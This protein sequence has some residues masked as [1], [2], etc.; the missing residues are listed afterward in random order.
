[1]R[2]RIFLSALIVVGY[3]ATLGVSSWHLAEWYSLTKGTLP[4]WL[5]FA[6]A[7]T[8][9]FNA[10]LLSFLSNSFLAR[11]PWARGG[12]VAALG[13]VWLGNLLSMRRSAPD[14]AMWE[15]VAAS[16]F[17]PVGT[18][19]MAK[20]MGELWRGEA[21]VK[22]APREEAAGEEERVL[23]LLEKP[24]RVRDLVRALPELRDA[25]PALLE[26]LE[27]EG[28]IRFADGYWTRAEGV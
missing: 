16:L 27:R 6:L 9:E 11:S 15:V 1:M 7:V 22:E 26:K 24:A 13:L 4:S 21:A 5:S 19:V 2:I 18:F 23:A 17:V 10:F 8:L 3:G 12:A 14:L 20:V 25:L 28:R